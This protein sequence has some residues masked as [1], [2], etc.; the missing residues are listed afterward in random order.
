MALQQ[1]TWVAL[2]CSPNQVVYYY[3]TAPYHEGKLIYGIH[4]L[5]ELLAE[6]TVFH[7]NPYFV[8]SRDNVTG[9]CSCNLILD[10]SA[11]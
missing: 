2:Q 6:K 4:P 3:T 5:F 10:S 11:P 1:Y 9:F 7:T 8:S